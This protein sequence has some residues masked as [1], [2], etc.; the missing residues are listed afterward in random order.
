MLIDPHSFSI[1]FIIIHDFIYSLEKNAMDTIK[2]T[3]IRS[4][5]ILYD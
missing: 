1:F 3:L 5:T 2:L 4:M